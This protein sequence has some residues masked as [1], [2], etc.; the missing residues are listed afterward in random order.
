MEVWYRCKLILPNAAPI[1]VHLNT[2]DWIFS[3]SDSPHPPA[4]FQFT[5]HSY[6]EGKVAGIPPWASPDPSS[7]RSGCQEALPSS[8]P[9][10]ATSWCPGSAATSC[11]AAA[12]STWPAAGW[13]SSPAA[14]TTSPA[15]AAAAAVSST[16]L[17]AAAGAVAGSAPWTAGRTGWAAAAAVTMWTVAGRT[18]SSS[19]ASASSSWGAA[20]GRRQGAA[21]G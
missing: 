10:S 18:R 1:M 20:A 3:F 21:T 15:A 5:H 16:C 14:G 11:L 8:D 12:K 2:E 7:G 4:P 17:A 19:P 13:T 9:R 6:L